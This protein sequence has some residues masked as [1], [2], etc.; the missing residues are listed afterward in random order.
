MDSRGQTGNSRSMGRVRPVRADRVE[1]GPIGLD[2]FRFGPLGRWV[3]GHV[4]LVPKWAKGMGAR[5]WPLAAA[6]EVGS[7]RRCKAEKRRGK[8][9][10]KK[11]Q[12]NIYSP[13]KGGSP[14][15]HG[16]EGK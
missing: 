1:F 5:A 6:R 3:L 14:A 8:N 12:T 10:G 15:E 11:E 9:R 16:G 13:R 7:G 2:R 4:M